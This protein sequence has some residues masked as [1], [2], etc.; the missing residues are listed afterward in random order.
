MIDRYTKG[1]LTIIAA[2]LLWLSVKDF[3]GVG[4]AAA[5]QHQS[6][7]IKGI[8]LEKDTAPGGT[9]FDPKYNVLPTRTN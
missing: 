8:A 4:P 2:C 9:W 3:V 1:V 7:V 5:T 6:V